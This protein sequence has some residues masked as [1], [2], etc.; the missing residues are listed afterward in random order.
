[1]TEFRDA[2]LNVINTTGSFHRGAALAPVVVAT[3]VSNAPQNGTPV[4][5]SRVSV[6]AP[7]TVLALISNPA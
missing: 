4:S 2:N 6:T 7:G 5:L 3:G 1:M